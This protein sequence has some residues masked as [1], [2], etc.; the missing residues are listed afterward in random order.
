MARGWSV[1]I[2][3]ARAQL[4][5]NT[6]LMKCRVYI[7]IWLIDI[8]KLVF[9]VPV[10][11]TAPASW[12]NTLNGGVLNNPFSI[13][14]SSARWNTH[15]PACG[16]DTQRGK[17]LNFQSCE[18]GTRVGRNQMR[19]H[20]RLKQRS[21]RSFEHEGN[22]V[23][24]VAR[25]SSACASHALHHQHQTHCLL[26]QREARHG[27][28]FRHKTNALMSLGKCLACCLQSWSSM[29]LRSPTI[30]LSISTHIHNKM[31][32]LIL[33]TEINFFLAIYKDQDRKC[34]FQFGII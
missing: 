19:S 20:L 29:W 22:K 16:N 15:V 21:L 24:K 23:I 32:K 25:G 33:K 3:E 18:C 8:I 31:C 34:R 2:T 11:Q 14:W 1:H 17:A 5:A 12:I 27:F 13:V 10:S 4:P 9:I 26:A 6:Q 30:F 28:C 7:N